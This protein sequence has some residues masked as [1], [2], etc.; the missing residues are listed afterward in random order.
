MTT[1]RHPIRRIFGGQVTIKPNVSLSL[2]H[3]ID[4]LIRHHNYSA[5]KFLYAKGT[6]L[7]DSIESVELFPASRPLYA[8]DFIQP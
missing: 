7:W 3:H 2:I 1:P 5:Q 4:F 6:A 8:S